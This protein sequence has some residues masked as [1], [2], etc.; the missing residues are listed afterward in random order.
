LKICA[1]LEIIEGR[2]SSNDDLLERL[3]FALKSGRMGEF[4]CDLAGGTMLWDARMH[5]LFGINPGSFSGT[6]DDFLALVHLEDRPRLEREMTAALGKDAEFAVKFRVIC[7]SASAVRFLA[8]GCKVHSGT[9]GR[10]RRFTG[11]CWEVTDP[12]GTEPVVVP[13]QYLL[14]TM[15]DNLQDLIY[16]KDRESRF[17]AVNRLFLCRAGFKD[18]SEIIGKTDKDL[19]AEEHALAAL[20]DEQ[21]IIATGEPI[22]G[23]EEKETW[24]DGHETWV[25]TS[26]VPIRDASGK[27]IGTFGLSRDITE[28]RLANE[29][30]ANHARQQE[31]VSQLGQR[32]LAGAEMVE[33]FDQAVQLITRTLDVEL[34]AVFEFQPS[35]GDTLRLVAGVGWNEGY[36]GSLVVPALKQSQAGWKPETDHPKAVDHPRTEGRFSMATL[37]R[38]HDVKGGVCVDIEGTS[39][40]YGVLAAHS[41]RSRLFSQHEV[42]FL[43]SVAYTLRAAIERK[44]VE[45]ELRESKEMAET[46]NRAK[47]Q[48]LAN[49]SHEI[50][51][52]MNCVIGMSGMLLDT[53]LDPEQREIVDAI[54]TAGESLL[55]IINDIL[56]FS[57]IEAG[58]LTFEL[59]DFDLIETVE[60]A[61]EI[62]AES[63]Y[64]KGIELAC[65][66]PSWVGAGLRGDPGRLRQVLTNLIGNAIKFTQRGDVVLRVSQESETA[67]H[68]ELRFA[69]Q[70]TGIGILEEVQ[71]RLFQAFTQADSSSSRKYGGTGLGLAIAKQLVEM[72]HG[73]I[74]VQS[75]P[76][77]GSVFWFTALFE[78]QVTNVKQAESD[79]REELNLRVLVVQRSATS[80][81][82][83]CRQIVGW[84][85]QPTSAAG[86]E[87]ALKILRAAAVAGHP[88]EVALLDLQMADMNGLTLSR[89]IKADPEICATQLVVL[90]PPGKAISPGKLKELGIEA[91]LVKPVKQSRLFDCLI[92]AIGT[93]AAEK[94]PAKPSALRSDSIDSQTNAQSAKVRILLAEDNIINQKVALGQL[95]KLGYTADA[96]ANG[97]EVLEALQR[98]PYAIIFMD[99]HMPEMDG[100]ETTQAIRKREGGSA[101]N[102]GWKSPVHIIAMTADALHTNI[103]KCLMIGMNDYLTKPVGLRDLKAA[104]ERWNRM[105]QYPGHARVRTP[106]T[107]S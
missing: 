35:G 63:A 39:S 82:I 41:R 1:K 68:V 47:D 26:K 107:A 7:P 61:F 58:K 67:T 5:E 94:A 98:I 105:V 88:F 65:E 49:M 80:R 19:Y 16:F 97:L 10:P 96:V 48:F 66:I 21:K 3:N 90:T 76:G 15:M 60:G 38:A 11:L 18:Q 42:K 93:I 13:E 30:L 104:L 46:A 40:P 24:P 43:E 27:V 51:T 69:V 78:K 100:Y 17:T 89:V 102:C 45:N 36:V 79:H 74:G 54:S 106:D 83:L 72:M 75:A 34:G 28:R 87:E 20:A 92:Y 55:T 4:D 56:D 22:L 37:L 77:K 85:F 52:P 86:G 84:K 59:L 33:L 25:S 6:Y 62:L 91:S 57:K 71:A 14:S 9:E 99:C 2:A 103:E 64:G 50:R 70:D 95:R 53:K 31:A 44:R 101:E 23:I 12:G 32:G 29:A 81:E 73:Q 8:M